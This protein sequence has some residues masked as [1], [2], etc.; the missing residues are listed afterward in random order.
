MCE[1]IQLFGTLDKICMWK[2]RVRK[3]KKT[4]SGFVVTKNLLVSKYTVVDF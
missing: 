4:N 3:M 1:I 2:D